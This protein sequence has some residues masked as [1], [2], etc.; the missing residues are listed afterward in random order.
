M[1]T[2]TVSMTFPP[3]TPASTV[4][5]QFAQAVYRSI[6]QQHGIDTSK[7]VFSAPPEVFTAA[8]VAV[9]GSTAISQAAVAA[10]G[11]GPITVSAV[12]DGASGKITPTPKLAPNHITVDTSVLDPNYVMPTSPP[13]Q[14]NPAS[15]PP[16][17]A[18]PL[19]GK[20]ID[21]TA[22]YGAGGP[23][24]TPLPS[25]LQKI[26]A[27]GGTAAGGVIGAMAAG[28]IGMLAGLAVGGGVDYFRAK[29]KAPL[30]A[31]PTAPTGH[32]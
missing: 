23:S 31:H 4:Q 14:V 10:A 6:F 13:T 27:L 3:G 8:N 15:H 1:G 2:Q 11:G 29:M 32:S 25:G 19:T 28:P 9:P 21:Q 22:T 7:M 20:P 5:T 17:T 12:V 24:G 18:D 30:I 16:R 26:L